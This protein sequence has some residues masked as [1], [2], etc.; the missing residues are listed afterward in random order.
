MLIVSGFS[1]LI[2]GIGN[3][4]HNLSWNI[5][6]YLNSFSHKIGTDQLIEI[7]VKKH[8]KKKGTKRLEISEVRDD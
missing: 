3:L 1:M 7:Y 5:D 8:T 6:K 2:Q 4:L